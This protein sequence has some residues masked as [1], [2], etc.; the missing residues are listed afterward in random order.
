MRIFTARNILVG[1]LLLGSLPAGAANERKQAMMAC[2]EDGAPIESIVTACT[3]L[4]ETAYNLSENLKLSAYLKRAVAR[5]RAGEYALAI[6]D[7]DQAIDMSPD[8]SR[9]RQFR[10]V[11]YAQSGNYKKAVSNQSRA[12][13]LDKNNAEAWFYR[14]YDY[15]RMEKFSKAIADYNHAIKLNPDFL[16][17]INNRGQL[18][19][20]MGDCERALVDFNTSLELAPN[21]GLALVNRA[22]C[23]FAV[24][25]VEGSLEDHRRSIELMPDSADAHNASCWTKGLLG[26]GEGALEDCNEA[27]RLEPGVAAMLDSRALAYYRLHQYDLALADEMEAMKEPTWENHILRA[28]IYQQQGKTELAEADYRAAKGLQRDKS[29]LKQRIQVLGLEPDA[30]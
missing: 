2:L 5:N 11:T 24:G 10:G 12:I 26:D 17:A 15:S 21:S 16:T 8:S 6:K 28:A 22:E 4:L 27:L 7:I 14:G 9:L 30:W 18:Y 1:L 13:R 19:Y 3:W 25:N 20:D 23:R 29:I